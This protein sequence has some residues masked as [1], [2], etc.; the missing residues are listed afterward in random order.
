MA[1]PDPYYW[2]K[3]RKP[4]TLDRGVILYTAEGI[5]FGSYTRSGP[6]WKYEIPFSEIATIEHQKMR[7][8]VKGELK[9][10]RE[11]EFRIESQMNWAKDSRV[12]K[13]TAVALQRVQVGGDRSV[14]AIGSQSPT[15]RTKPCAV[16]GCDRGRTNG[17]YCAAHGPQP[18]EPKGCYGCLGSALAGL[19]ALA[20]IACVVLL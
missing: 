7:D 1:K 16:P 3:I 17:S 11:F 8:V 10:G 12:A 18:Q 9:D 2:A 15:D 14:R 4:M 20:A 19:S 6:V 5:Q 13:A